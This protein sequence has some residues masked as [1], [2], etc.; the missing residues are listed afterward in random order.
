M[1]TSKKIIAGI[2]YAVFFCS[3]IVL[4]I[5]AYDLLFA[6]PLVMKGIIVEKMH[7]PKDQV[8]ATSMNPYMRYKQKDYLITTQKHDQWV[9]LVELED[10]QVL[11]VNCHSDHYEKKL[12]GDTLHFKEYAGDIM[13]IDYFSH[14]EEDEEAENL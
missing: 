4:G 1:A 2:K 12:V 6:P 7:I 8:N 11:K 5:F 3:L 14:N 9:A 10:G 13:G